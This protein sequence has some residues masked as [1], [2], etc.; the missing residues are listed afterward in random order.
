ML[1]RFLLAAGLLALILVTGWAVRAWRRRARAALVDQVIVPRTATVPRVIQ[2]S[3]PRCG[4]CRSQKTVIERIAAERGSAVEI[5][6]LDAVEHADLAGKYRVMTV[7]TTVVTASDGRV[8]AINAG[9][10]TADKLLS[11]LAAA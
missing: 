6:F 11:Q 10:A 7:P 5:A 9:F 4:A 1:E 8:V 3:G 2:F